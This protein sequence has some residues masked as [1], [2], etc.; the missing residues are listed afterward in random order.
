[1]YDD[2]NDVSS[3]LDLI[4]SHE[5]RAVDN[6]ILKIS[7]E[8]PSIKTAIVFPP[9]I[10][11]KGDGPVKQ[12][13]VQIPALS[14]VAIERGHAVRGGKGLAAWTNVHVA[15]L[16]RLFVLLTEKAEKGDDSDKIWGEN[17]IYFPGVG[18]MVRPLS[19]L[20]VQLLTITDVG[21]NLRQG[22]A[23]SKGTG[24]Y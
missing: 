18:E 8:T 22:R 14:K 15:D 24:T 11:G 2:L 13:S 19:L 16:A 12:R 21:R 10:Y 23:S 5:S 7:Q 1:M 3:I 4:R 17:G 9:I 6:A 20:Q